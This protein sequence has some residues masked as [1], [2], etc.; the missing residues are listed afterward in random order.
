VKEARVLYLDLVGGASGDMLLGALIDAGASL[1][2]IEKTWQ[3][4]GL[5]GVEAKI[6]EAFPAGLRAKRVQILVGGREA[7][8]PGHA[9]REE[10]DGHYHEHRPYSEI[11]ARL[12]AATGIAPR[13]RAIA[14]DAFRRLAVAEGHVHGVEIEAVEFH[15]VGSDD[16]IA[17]IT[18]V[19]TA[20][21]ELEPEEILVS[22][23]PL[24]RGLAHGAHGPIP[25]PGPATLELLKGAPIE[26]V[27]LEGETVT[28]TGAALIA[29]IATRYGPA[30]AMIIEATGVAAGRK[31][32]PDRPNIVRALLGRRTGTPEP[33]EED[34]I[35]EAN[36]DDMSPELVPAL[37]RALFSAGA[38]DVWSTAIAMK[39]GRTGVLVSA[40]VRRSLT[41]SIAS[42]F[43]LHSTTLGVRIMNVAR[44]RVER[45]TETVETR[46]GKVRIKVSSRPCGAPLVAPEYEDCDALAAQSG[47]SVREVM[48]AALQAAWAKG[49]GE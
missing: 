15:E 39:K 41:R 29:A 10:A 24:G 6:E 45:S 25:L 13:A 5:S 18:G 22:P 4:I 32:W 38:L 11:R 7:D 17:D 46:F 23:I 49:S 34:C 30:P 37:E 27:P 36:L 12:E 14:L 1:D 16:A 42:T 19:S 2:R 40:L 43:L 9:H 47:V 44:I 48:E 31:R 3:A 8:S 33:A 35:V 21:A 20:I 28:P 26:G